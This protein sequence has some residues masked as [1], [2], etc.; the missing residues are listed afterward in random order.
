M[1]NYSKI[2]EMSKEDLAEFL[3]EHFNCLSC[4]VYEKCNLRGDSNYLFEWL[5]NNSKILF[6]KDLEIGDKFEY[7]H[8]EYVKIEDC[9]IGEDQIFCNAVKLNTGRFLEFTDLQNVTKLN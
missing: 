6:F 3:C 9:K 8:N 2:K 7:E 1:T 5:G 4:P